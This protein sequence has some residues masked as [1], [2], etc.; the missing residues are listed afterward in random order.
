M[1]DIAII[2]VVYITAQIADILTTNAVLARGGYEKNPV[3]AALMSIFAS[4]WPYWK[5]CL[6]ILAACIM[7]YFGRP[8]YILVV[9][10]ITA[11]FAMNNWWIIRSKS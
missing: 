8:E 2:W 4:W 11:A 5:A 3:V 1:A 9:G 7:Q 6:A 10:G